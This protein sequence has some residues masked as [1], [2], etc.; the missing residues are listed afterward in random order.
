MASTS[1]PPP[2]LFIFNGENYHI[3]VVKMKIYLQAYDLW[4][5]VNT[6][7][8]LTPVM[9][10]NK[11][12]KRY[13]AMS[14]IQNEFSDVIFT[15]I[16]ACETL[17][18]AWDKLN[19]EFQG[20]DKTRQQLINLRRDFENLKMKEVEI[21]KQYADKIML[22]VNNIRLLREE[23]ADSKVVEKVITTLPEISYKQLGH[24][25]K[26]CRNK[27]RTPQQ[28]VQAQEVE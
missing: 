12:A 19:E 6:D 11:R 7:V 27:G 24:M 25:E 20:S 18:K 13:K 23:F 28:H 14:C 8:E 10:R 22:V 5:V 4:E 21:V 9:P 3:R 2:S 1:S 26:V 15:R 17:K 16:M